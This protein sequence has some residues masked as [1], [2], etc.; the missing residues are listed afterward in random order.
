M[1]ISS[2]AAGI[3][4]PLGSLEQSKEIQV[5]LMSLGKES[6][7]DRT[8]AIKAGVGNAMGETISLFQG[9]STHYGGDRA[10]HHKELITIQI[11]HLNL[12]S[13]KEDK[14]PIYSDVP[15]LAIHL[16]GSLRTNLKKEIR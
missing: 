5:V 12:L 11:H 16:P 6:P 14:T 15:A 1:L 7:R 4:D 9:H 13:S 2:L 10:V 8:Y 3:D